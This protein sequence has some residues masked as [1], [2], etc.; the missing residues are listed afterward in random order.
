MCKSNLKVIWKLIGILIKRKIKSQIIFQK[1]VRNNKIY[2][3]IEDIVDQFNKYFINVGL[4]LVSKIDKSN[5][6]FI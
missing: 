6:N 4:N 2:I 5:D 1:I 3:S